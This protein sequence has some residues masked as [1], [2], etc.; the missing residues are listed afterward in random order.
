M[1]RTYVIE[2]TSHFLTDEGPPCDGCRQ[3]EIPRWDKRTF[4][5]PGEHDKIL[6]GSKRWKDKGTEHGYWDGGILRKMENNTVWVMDIDDIYEFAV[7]HGNHILV[8]HWMWSDPRNP[9]PC[10]EIYD[11]YRE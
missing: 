11:D 5:S 3:I 2:R 8:S 4:K 9:T 7:E 10:L 6:R 1:K